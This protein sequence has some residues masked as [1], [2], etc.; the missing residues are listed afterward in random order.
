MHDLLRVTARIARLA[1]V[2]VL[3]PALASAGV[4]LA[5]VS[6][7]ASAN[8][9]G[10]GDILHT[11]DQSGLFTPYVSGVTDFDVYIASDPRHDYPAAENAWAAEAADIPIDLDYD[12]GATYSIDSLALWT[13]WG[14]YST[15]EFEVF[16]ASD[17]SF[18]GAVS[19]GTYNANDT[20]PPL[21]AQVI[22]LPVTDGRFLRLR[23]LSTTAQGAEYVNHS[24][25]AVEVVS[26][27]PVPEPFV[28]SLLGI[29]LAARA[30]QRR[31]SAGFRRRR[32]P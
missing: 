10:G 14:G 13:S 20:D 27:T 25:T 16:V 2:V 1:I 7:T 24:E 8:T 21:A 30:L 23:I 28:L 15:G 29:G 6:A 4:I 32:Q 5:P 3:F 11:I 9:P 26:A 31:A 18:A 19:L 22:D 17:A 12:L